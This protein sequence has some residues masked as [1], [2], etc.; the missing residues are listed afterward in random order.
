MPRK[1]NGVK[2]ENPKNTVSNIFYLAV[3]SLSSS[4]EHVSSF[5]DLFPPRHFSSDHNVD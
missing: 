2:K 1:R 4:G 3:S 5:F